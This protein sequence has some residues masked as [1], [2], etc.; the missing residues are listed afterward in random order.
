MNILEKY[1]SYVIV[2]GY[3]SIL[4]GRSRATE[5]VDLIMDRMNRHT[6]EKFYADLNIHG[7]WCLNGEDCVSLW[8]DYLMK[9]TALRFA[10]KGVVIPNMEIKFPRTDFDEKTITS[11]LTVLLGSAK[12]RIGELEQQIAYKRIVLGSPKD[13]E[14]A[15]HLQKTFQIDEEKINKHEKLLKYYA[16]SKGT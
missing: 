10:R 11:A 14:D 13:F 5:D 16:R 4:F 12:L 2:S 9:Q 7:F 3:V 1:T 6:F 15:R 8:D